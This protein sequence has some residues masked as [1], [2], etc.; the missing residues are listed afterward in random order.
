[1]HR[2]GEDGKALGA[3]GS[4]GALHL[5]RETIVPGAF[6]ASSASEASVSPSDIAPAF[7][8]SRGPRR[9]D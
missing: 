4:G 8:P 1:L 6:E 2:C 5:Q 3:A 9:T 7:V